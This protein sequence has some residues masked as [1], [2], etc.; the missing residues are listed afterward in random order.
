MACGQKYLTIYL[1]APPEIKE[2]NLYGL[3]QRLV[4]LLTYRL[5][6]QLRSATRALSSFAQT[7]KNS[8]NIELQICCLV[9]TELLKLEVKED[10]S[11][12]EFL[13]ILV[14]LHFTAVSK[15]VSHSFELA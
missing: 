2:S 1:F 9:K 12:L 10:I 3:K 15:S 7:L 6:G 13:A 11:L 14:A 5:K 4:C 8:A